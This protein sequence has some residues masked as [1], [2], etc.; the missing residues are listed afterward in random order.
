MT[1]AATK[2]AVTSHEHTLQR[3]HETLQW[4][5]G[6]ETGSPFWLAKRLEFD[7]DPLRDI[8]T[9]A[10][11]RRF[12]DISSQLRDLPADELIPKG[13]ANEVYHVF[14]SGG[15]SGAPKR[16]VESSSRT[17]CVDWCNDVLDQHG[18]PERGHWLHVGPSGPHVVG[19]SIRRL[20]ELRRSL[21]FTVDM[22]PRWVRK[23]LAEGR[24]DL[25]Q[26]Y[27][28]HLLDQLELIV[29][30]QEIRV[31]FITPPVLEA[32]C[33]RPAIY[34]RLRHTLR[35]ILWA[36]TTASD[37]TLRTIEDD[38]FPDASVAGWYGNTLMGIAPQ[39]P[40]RDDDEFR[41][42]FQTFHPA[43]IVEVVDFDSRSPVAYGERGRVLMHLLT[44]DMFLPNVLERDTA[45]RVQAPAGEP[46][47]LTRIMPHREPGAPEI[48]EGVY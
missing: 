45:I 3:L 42:I 48:I 22:D 37:E 10:D 11:L 7:F 17:L 34:D 13:G 21:C 5:F 39:R 38:L 14:D 31:L 24:T 1:P 20:A 23:L 6:S 25:A 9:L 16:V 36:G 41:C 18:F 12:P 4:H 19:R 35:G 46:D 47:E 15:T 29:A 27:T 26:E 43:S 28:A 40:Q 44:R 33:A 32:V 8:T 2:S 30:T